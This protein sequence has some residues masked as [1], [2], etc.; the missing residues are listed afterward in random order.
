MA[1]VLVLLSPLLTQA[2]PLDLV[3]PILFATGLLP[4]NLELSDWYLISA[5]TGTHVLMFLLLAIHARLMFGLLSKTQWPPLLSAIPNILA[6]AMVAIYWIGYG[7]A[8]LS[9][10]AKAGRLLMPFWLLAYVAN[11]IAWT[12]VAMCA[13]P[14]T[15]NE[16]FG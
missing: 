15:A 9:F 10:F 12:I 5:A 1:L 16:S 2:A 11:V 3:A 13:K 14:V 6:A 8:E 7:T 4:M